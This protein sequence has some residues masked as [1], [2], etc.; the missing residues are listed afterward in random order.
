MVFAKIAIFET[1]RVEN[2]LREFTDNLEKALKFFTNTQ[3]DYEIRDILREYSKKFDGFSNNF[4]IGSYGGEQH[5]LDTDALKDTL[6]NLSDNLQQAITQSVTSLSENLTSANSAN[7]MESHNIQTCM[8][9][10]IQKIS[11][12][13]TECAENLRKLDFISKSVEGLLYVLEK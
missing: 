7:F 10:E 6:E 3:V 1:A 5:K 13:Q 11:D 12:T 9:T 2:R 8:H 4:A